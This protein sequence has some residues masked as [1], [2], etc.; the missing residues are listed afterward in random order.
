[1]PNTE[2]ALIN[3]HWLM[4]VCCIV[5][6]GKH[7]LIWIYLLIS[8]SDHKYQKSGD[9]LFILCSSLNVVEFIYTSFHL[10]WIFILWL[11]HLVNV[12]HFLLGW[13]S[14]HN[15]GQLVSEEKMPLLGCHTTQC[16]KMNTV[17]S[18]HSSLR[19]T[20]LENVRELKDCFKDLCNCYLHISQNLE[21]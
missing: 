18:K 6:F 3:H 7:G 8:S 5:S 1:M 9:E 4:Y 13:Q 21:C 2:L 12:C 11:K 19:V 10:S 15:A 14:F 20:G 16:S 17:T